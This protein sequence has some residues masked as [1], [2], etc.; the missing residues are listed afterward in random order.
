MDIRFRRA[1]V[2][3]ALAAA[4]PLAAA[5]DVALRSAVID[6]STVYSP[7]ALFAFYRAELGQPITGD[8]AKRIAAAIAAR[9]AEDGYA[10]PEL[11]LDPAL[12]KD[13]VL[14]IAVHE[15]RV[16]RVTV[17]G[18]PGRHRAALE[19]IGRGVTESR[20]LRRDAIPQAVAAARRIPGLS[21]TP[22]TRRVA[23]EPGAY[24]LVLDAE[25]RTLTGQLRTNNRG[26]DAIGPYFLVGQL[27][28]N[29]LLG[30]NER[31]GLLFS[32]AADTSEYLSG[33]LWFD[34]PVGD[35]GTRASAL[36]FR[37]DSSPNE[38][39]TD[40]TDEYARERLALTVT[41][42]LGQYGGADFVLTGA[43]EAEDLT[44]DRDGVDVRDDRVRVVEAGLRAGW[45][46]GFATRLSSTLELRKGLDALGSGL[47]ADD[48]PTDPRQE[49][50]LVAQLQVGST[51]RFADTWSL[52]V[53]VFAQVT[54]DVLPDSERFKIGGERLGRGFEVAEIAGDQGAGAKFV[55]RRD[56]ASAGAPVRPSLYALYDYGAAW[57]EDA[58]GRESAATGGLGFAL[59]GSSLTGYL[60]I[61]RP[62][63]HAD[64]EGKRSTSVFAEIG[65]R[66]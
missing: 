8:T 7:Q 51:T 16:S 22:A 31:V 39:P 65:W 20:P 34:A 6:G 47:R 46:A 27:S 54:G 32:A 28:A 19:R 23:G 9:Y 2:I 66:F 52:R 40:L 26:T 29:D 15:P 50:F 4:A 21:V 25:F 3:I 10:R 56:L 12:A 62:I 63:G 49:D 5:E 59:D 60:E 57:K 30:R 11:R 43:F 33:G 13:G 18:S 44:V 14:R 1:V 42:P 64:I 53:D 35:G 41:H 48:L 37:S 36:V 61:A 24:E 38:E 45:R 17:E 58:G 55:L